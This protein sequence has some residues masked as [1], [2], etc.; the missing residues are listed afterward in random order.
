VQGDA[1]LINHSSRCDFHA[2]EIQDWA[3]RAKVDENEGQERLA[4]GAYS[5]NGKSLNHHHSCFFYRERISA[6][7][8]LYV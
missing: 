8:Y 2:V 1:A 5:R 6:S 7:T 4:V 3:S